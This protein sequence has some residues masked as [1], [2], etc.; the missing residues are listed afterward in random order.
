MAMAFFFSVGLGVG[1]FPII[2][3]QTHKNVLE[4]DLARA[5]RDSSAFN[6]ALRS[7][8]DLTNSTRQLTKHSSGRSKTRAA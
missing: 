3:F 4:P 2:D 7:L 5:F 1:L 8:L 6:E